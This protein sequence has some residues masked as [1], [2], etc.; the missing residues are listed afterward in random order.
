MSGSLYTSSGRRRKGRNRSGWRR[1]NAFLEAW[2]RAN[3]MVCPGLDGIP[4]MA[5]KLEVDHVVPVALG[6]G[7][8][9]GL[10]VLCQTCNR[11]AGARLGN[12]LNGRG[13]RQ[14]RVW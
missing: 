13:R 6:G 5:T 10:R 9:D 8:R 1:R 2:I 14:S 3:G 7:D 11:S 4:H 12:A